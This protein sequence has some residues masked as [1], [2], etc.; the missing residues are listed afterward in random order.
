MRGNHLGGN[1]SY[2]REVGGDG[3]E[4][5]QYEFIHR[6]LVVGDDEDSLAYFEPAF[7]NLSGKVYKAGV[8]LGVKDEEDV[9]RLDK[10]GSRTQELYVDL[11]LS[12][13]SLYALADLV[14]VHRHRKGDDPQ[15]LC[16]GVVETLNKA[17]VDIVFEVLIGRSELAAKTRLEVV[18]QY[19]LSYRD[20]F[21][22]F[23]DSFLSLLIRREVGRYDI[24]IVAVKVCV[25]P[26]DLLVERMLG[27][28]VYPDIQ[29]K[30]LFYAS[31]VFRP[32]SRTRVLIVMFLI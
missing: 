7:L 13:E 26:Y 28:V 8:Q 15:A 23:D 29:K 5:T 18:D 12:S 31:G 20:P 17:V 10:V 22:E 19:Q 14:A 3:S 24:V 4:A 9:A 16:R 21:K 25:E 1:T 27:P 11:F 6:E 2:L 32:A 30:Y